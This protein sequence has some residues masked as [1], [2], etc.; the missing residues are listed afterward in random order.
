MS[1]KVSKK[2]WLKGSTVSEARGPNM[3]AGQKEDSEYKGFLSLLPGHIDVSF[4]ALAQ[5]PTLKHSRNN[6]PS[7]PTLHLSLSQ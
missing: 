3:I 7:K 1:P 2:E 4:S 6:E 5:H